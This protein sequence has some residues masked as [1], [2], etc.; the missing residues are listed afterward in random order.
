M[1]GSV[2]RILRRPIPGCSASVLPTGRE[3]KIDRGGAGIAAAD[4]GFDDAVVADVVGDRVVRSRR[5]R[6]RRGAASLVF[7]AVVALVVSAAVVRLGFGVRTA[8]RQ[9][10]AECCGGDGDEAGAS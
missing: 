9:A 8:G 10:E 6:R 5:L 3:R 1:A 2:K 4:T 7:V